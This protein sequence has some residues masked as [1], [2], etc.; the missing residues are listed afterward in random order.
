MKK[1]RINGN[2]RLNTE[3]IR[4][5]NFKTG[6]RRVLSRAKRFSKIKKI[7]SRNIPRGKRSTSPLSSQTYLGKIHKK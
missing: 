1:L 2:G 6:L 7:S 4:I 5:P 3:I